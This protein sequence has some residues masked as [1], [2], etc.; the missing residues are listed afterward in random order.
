MEKQEWEIVWSDFLSVGVPEMDDEH[1]QFVARVNELNKA[2]IESEDKAVVLRAVERL[3]NDAKLHFL[4]EEEL[5]EKWNYP[6][7]ADH[8][9]LHVEL[10]AQFERATKEIAEDELS[11]VWALKA[12]RLK[13]ALV[14]HLVKEDR[15]YHDFLQA[16][17]A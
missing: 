17:Q 9:A 3:L 5:L 2:I 12:L 7:L 4:H 15:K 1:R 13:Q 16:R 6:E 14:E 11:F 8:I 10:R